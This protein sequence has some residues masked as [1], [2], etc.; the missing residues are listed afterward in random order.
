MTTRHDFFRLALG[1]GFATALPKLEAFF[2]DG[3]DR[4]FEIHD[5]GRFL[6]SLWA[7]EIV[8]KYRSG[9]AQMMRPLQEQIDQDIIKIALR[10]GET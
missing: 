1:A 9:L 10:G 2:P 8:A 4:T 5:D 7:D 6:A 3:L